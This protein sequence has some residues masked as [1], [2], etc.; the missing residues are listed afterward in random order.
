MARRVRRG[1]SA[2]CRNLRGRC[3]SFAERE[4]I[5]LS[6]ARG[7][8]MRAITRRLGRSPSTV[9]RELGRNADRWLPTDSHRLGASPP[10]PKTA[11]WRSRRRRRQ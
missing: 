2:P 1:A 6:R 8:S 10:E 11:A 3:L 4:E 5:A 7:E 9:S